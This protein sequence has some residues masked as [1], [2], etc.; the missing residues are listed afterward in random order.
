MTADMKQP[1]SADYDMDIKAEKVE[2]HS[3]PIR[4]TSSDEEEEIAT[5]HNCISICDLKC[6]VRTLVWICLFAFFVHIE[7]GMVYFMVSGLVIMYYSMKKRQRR[8]G[9]PSA[10]SVFNRHMQRITGTFMA[11]PLE[12]QLEYCSHG[13]LAI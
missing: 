13:I 9:E 11:K 2:L 3:V 6:V 8:P 12:Q 4:D 7:F 10:Y 5:V 1:G